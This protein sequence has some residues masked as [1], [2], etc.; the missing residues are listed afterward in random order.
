MRPDAVVIGKAVN[1]QNRVAFAGDEGMDRDVVQTDVL[2]LLMESHGM[3]GV[4][5]S[6]EAARHPA[7]TAPSCGTF[8]A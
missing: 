6:W 5:V 4:M 2:M 7:D 1:Q 8:R 3:P